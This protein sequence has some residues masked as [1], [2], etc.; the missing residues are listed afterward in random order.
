MKQVPP[1]PA[2]SSTTVEFLWSVVGD[3]T[4][5]WGIVDYNAD[6]NDGYIAEGF[7]NY[8]V[9]NREPVPI[10]EISQAVNV[11]LLIAGAPG[12][13]VNLFIIEN[14]TT[15]AQL[16]VIRVPGSPW[17]QSQT[18]TFNKIYGKS[19]EIIL[20]YNATKKGSNPVKILLESGGK[21]SC[22]ME[23]FKTMD[24]FD[25]STDINIEETLSFIIT[26]NL[27]FHFD[28]S[29][30][31]DLDGTII[32]F[33][34]DFGDNVTSSG[35]YTTHTYNSPGDYLVKLRITDDEGTTTLKE[36]LLHIG[37]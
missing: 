1:I 9:T 21:S 19:Y 28:A 6:I 8:I 22:L 4:T 17:S 10:V 7:V 36:Y 30:S 29:K 15:I 14:G 5:L 23:L 35:P 34:W 26:P 3:D 18:L 33:L 11:N 16:Q 25:Q 24:G 31:Y 32:S 2:N 37:Q 27:T 12:N 20:E 13:T